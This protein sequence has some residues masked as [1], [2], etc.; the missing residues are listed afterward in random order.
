MK[1]S[2][3][4]EVQDVGKIA[5]IERSSDGEL[6]V[7]AEYPEAEAEVSRILATLQGKELRLWFTS[8]ESPTKLKCACVEADGVRYVRQED[9]DY[10]KALA[11][12]LTHERFLGKPMRGV[13]QEPR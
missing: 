3:A 4:V 12:R 11:H 8:E 7:R 13:L 2:M 6:T 10:L 1:E 9:P 5:T